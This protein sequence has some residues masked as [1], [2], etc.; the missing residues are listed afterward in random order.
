[1]HFMNTSGGNLDMQLL[2]ESPVWKL[3][4]E[5]PL[6]AIAFAIQVGLA[7]LAKVHMQV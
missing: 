4:A 3:V 6:E 2:A 1:M 7:V 5:V